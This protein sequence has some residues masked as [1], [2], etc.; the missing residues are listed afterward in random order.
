M[1]IPNETRRV[2]RVLSRL[3]HIVSRV[4]LVGS[5]AFPR[6]EATDV[7]DGNARRVT[8]EGGT[9]APMY[10][11][12]QGSLA[13]VH[14]TLGRLA[15]RRDPRVGL[16]RRDAFAA[17]AR[18]LPV[19]T[20]LK[21]GA[22]T[23]SACA[24]D[25]AVAMF[26]FPQ[27]WDAVPQVVLFPRGRMLGQ[28]TQH[29]VLVNQHEVAWP[30]AILLDEIRDAS[31]RRYATRSLRPALARTV[32]VLARALRRRCLG[33]EPTRQRSTD[34]VGEALAGLLAEARAPAAVELATGERQ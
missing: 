3:P 13:S 32:P 9:G 18:V 30:K 26:A 5:C 25:V 23:L 11:P 22:W 8:C 21:L 16:R 33:T 34:V 29:E 14:G 15:C 28:Q 1:V 6:E 31:E 17:W 2:T 12:S 24:A 19:A 27:D 4:N 7:V 10:P 20:K